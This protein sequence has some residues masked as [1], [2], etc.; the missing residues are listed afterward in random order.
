MSKKWIRIILGLIILKPIFDL[1]WRWPLFYIGSIAIPFHRIVAFIVPVILTVILLLK[2]F[3]SHKIKIN[4]DIFAILVL[5][6]ITFP[7]LLNFNVYSLDEYF[8]TYNFFIIFLSVPVLLNSK[9]E[10][11]KVGKVMMLISLIPT[12][13][14]YLQVLGIFPFSYWDYLPII[15]KIGRVSGGYRHP[16]G[17][18][19]YLV[20][21]LPFLVYLFVN[22]AISK[23]FFWFWI[24]L[25]LPMI[26]RSFHR[27]TIIIVLLQI[28]VFIF[29]MRKKLTKYFAIIFFIFMMIIFFRPIWSLINQ[30]GAITQLKFRG[31][32]GSEDYAW[33]KYSRYFI[34]FPFYQQLIGF[35]SPKLPDDSYDPHSDWLRIT[36]NYGW[37]GLIFYVF[38][39]VFNV[40][41]FLFK[42]LKQ[43]ISSWINSPALIGLVLIMT[44]VLYSITMEPLR[45]S[46]FSWFCALVLGYVYREV[47]SSV[48]V[49]L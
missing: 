36:F 34:E 13:F 20:T 11:L 7:S 43:K 22:K 19:N 4:N 35:G 17:Y 44:I 12:I 29:L 42:L 10:F 32:T 45:Y 16:T 14:S 23:R 33:S 2:L 39:L 38:F 46:S 1:D 30:G 26:G 31:R 40:L 27:A 48:I 28:F 18:L 41:I 49:K 6:W 21:L 47:K 8:R 37:I 5:N 24:F 25:T 3:S 9:K 15:G